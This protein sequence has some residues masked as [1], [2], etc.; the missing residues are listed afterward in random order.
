MCVCVRE[1]GCV[2]VRV[3]VCEKER[4]RVCV[5][6]RVRDTVCVCVLGR[7]RLCVCVCVCVCLCVCVCVHVCMQSWVTLSLKLM[8]YYLSQTAQLAQ[9]TV[10]F[11]FRF[12]VR[13]RKSLPII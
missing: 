6:E 12:K 1:I 13:D 9:Q 4:D 3:C 2:C 8:Y 11:Q 5:C 10:S 7:E